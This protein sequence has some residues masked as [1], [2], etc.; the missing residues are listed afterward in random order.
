MKLPILVVKR[1]MFGGAIAIACAT[2]F[3]PWAIVGWLSQTLPLDDIS[4]T[5]AMA[6]TSKKKPVNQ[7]SNPIPLPTQERLEKAIAVRLH[8][9]QPPTPALPPEPAPSPTVIVNVAPLFDGQLIG[10][11]RDSD[12]KYCYAVLKWP[13]NR[14]QLVAQDAHLTDDTGSPVVS[15]IDDES[16]TLGKGEQ[17]QRIELR[18]SP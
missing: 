4:T 5:S 17:T 3:V 15:E 2:W 18:A 14:I 13:D 11:I 1:L 16:V 10:V 9:M 8:R 6:I 12:P 7:E